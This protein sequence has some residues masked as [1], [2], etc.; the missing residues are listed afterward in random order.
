MSTPDWRREYREATAMPPPGAKDRVW[1]KLDLGAKGTSRWLVPSVALAAAAAVAVVLW[2]RAEPGESK[3]WRTD[4]SVVSVEDARVAYEPASN[5]VTLERGTLTASVWSGPALHVRAL[6]RHIEVDSA[7]VAVSVAGD[8]VTVTPL[9]GS[10]LVDG[11][12]VESTSAT[13]E[14]AAPQAA[15]IEALE[16][17]EAKALRAATI[18]ERALESRR[19]ED[20]ARAFDEVAKSGSLGAEAAL[21]RKGEVELRNLDAPGRALATFEQGD[22]HFPGGSL[23]H[24]RALS[25]LEALSS[26]RRWAD[27]EARSARFLTGFPDSERANDVKML[28]ATALFELDRR[29]EACAEV[30][31]LTHDSAAALR[32][33]C[34]R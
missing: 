26:L 24:E 25:A 22:A 31:E 13:R 33:R 11:E 23:A 16:P 20:A 27:V 1:R 18:A 2:P 9:T 4:G 15:H 29:A 3:T 6:A 28:H 32:A 5:T 17:K 34:S 12:R 30:R 19:F 7:V 14:R 8:S 21:L 10:V